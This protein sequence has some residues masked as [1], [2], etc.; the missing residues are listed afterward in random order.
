MTADTIITGIALKKTYGGHAVAVLSNRLEALPREQ[1]KGAKQKYKVVSDLP[2][3]DEFHILRAK[4]FTT[5]VDAL[6]S[7]A[8]SEFEEL[9]GEL[10][11]WYDGMPENLQGGQKGE[12]LQSAIN[13][14]GDLQAP[15]V[16]EFVTNLETV[17]IP[18]EK[19][20]SRPSRRDDAVARIDTAIDILTDAM[21]D[22]DADVKYT[23]EQK[24]E[25]QQL[26]DDLETEKSNAEDIE[27]PTMFG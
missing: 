14:L 18:T 8:F 5:T 16:P 17:Y 3:V 19:V 27:F 15:D 4:K 24:G 2:S 23:D 13:T 11:E 6:V 26:I 22:E 12:D 10:E 1:K 25:M 9:K 20:E 21:D 7:D